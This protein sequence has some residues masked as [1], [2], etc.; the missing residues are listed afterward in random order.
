MYS[1][2][3]SAS[4]DSAHFLKGYNGKCANIHGHHWV[5]EI[6]LSGENLA[7][8]GEKRGMLMD[9]GDIKHEL[10]ELAK[11][12]DHAFIYEE[13]SLKEA[14][15][16]ALNDE[17]FRLINVPYRPTAENFAKAF[18]DHFKDKNYPVRCVRVFE[19]PKNCAEYEADE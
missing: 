15:V 4:F 3:T 7:D 13:G 17:D 2:K 12:Y 19:T 9:F 18:Y 14:T 1:I 6:V 8:E 10:R 11:Y 16:N 5:V